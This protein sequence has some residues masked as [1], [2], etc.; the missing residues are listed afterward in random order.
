MKLWKKELNCCKDGSGPS[1]VNILADRSKIEDCDEWDRK[2][3]DAAWKNHFIS[4]FVEPGKSNEASDRYRTQ[5]NSHYTS[6]Q[7][8]KAMEMYTQSLCFAELGTE[9]VSRAYANR[10]ACFEKLEMYDKSLRDIE[11]AAQANYPY[12]QNLMARK[13][14]CLELLQATPQPPE[15]QPRLS[16]AP[17]EQFPSMANVLDVQQNSEFGRHIVAKCD[18][19]VGQTV[20][21]ERSFVSVAGSN[22]RVQ[23]NTCLQTQ[24]NFIA[25]P[26]CTDVMFCDETCQR[27]NDV[28]RVFCGEHIH[29]MPPAIK[30]IAKSVLIAI[31]AYP[32]VEELLQFVADVVA[33]R[34]K[35]KLPAITDL[36][37]K[38]KLFLSLQP[39][40]PE[41]LNLELIYKIYTAL[42]DISRVKNLFDTMALQHFLMHLVGEHLLIILNNSYGGLDMNTARATSISLNLSLFNN[43]CAP[44]IFH[45]TTGYAEVCITMRPIKKGEQVFT[46]YLCDGRSTRER[47]EVL[48]E[49]W[50]FDCKCDKCRPHCSED[51]RTR[52]KTDPC[53]RLLDSS[54]Q[55]LEE[56]GVC[57]YNAL[58]PK[59]EQ[60]LRAYGHLPWSEEMDVA[61]KMYTRC[62][63]QEFPS[64]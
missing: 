35:D 45:S 15:F 53:Y 26:K 50:G 34:G 57:D 55:R 61:L 17:N 11:M 28:H 24:K 4:Q 42:M 8:M 22:D 2:I 59:C 62:L 12:M 47:C 5:G 41:E 30:Y 37:S 58:K 52:M 31:I 13:D 48:R 44:N 39:D 49:R 29:R 38:Y 43:A 9:N 32:N 19:D 33:K 60:F 7:Y 64:F 51:H 16:F 6:Q 46:K 10:A 18:I 54:L 21:V 1:F 23:C 14:R 20:L 27:Q 25:C 63:L 3:K 40:K 36:R 56:Y